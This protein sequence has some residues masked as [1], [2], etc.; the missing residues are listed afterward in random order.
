M[1]V[2]KEFDL[3][4]LWARGENALYTTKHG[5]APILAAVLRVHILTF[6]RKI[7]EV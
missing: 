1:L 7:N 6:L 2:T 5:T 3:A 4:A